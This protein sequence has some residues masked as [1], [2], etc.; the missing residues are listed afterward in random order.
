MKG[1]STLVTFLALLSTISGILIS[2]MSLVGKVSIFFFHKDYGL[3]K[4]WWQTALLAFSI[5]LVIVIILWLNRRLLPYWIS[6]FMI[7]M[8]LLIGALG[9]Y[10]TYIDLTTTNHRY[11]RH[12][13]QIGA[14]LFW[15]G[16]AIN[17][18]YFMIAGRRK[19]PERPSPEE[20][21]LLHEDNLE[22]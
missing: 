15:A 19:Y 8:I 5:H 6:F 10:W 1:L 14:Y 4:I 12:N 3:L 17:C 9:C 13:F 11:L 7:F 18:I 21:V 20:L 22:N 2:Q 16:W